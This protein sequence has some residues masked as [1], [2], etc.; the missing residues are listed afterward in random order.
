MTSSLV[1]ISDQVRSDTNLA[2]IVFAANLHVAIASFF[3]QSFSILLSKRVTSLV[4][5]Y[6]N[7]ECFQDFAFNPIVLV[8][9]MLFP[10]S[11]PVY[12]SSPVD[13]SMAVALCIFLFHVMMFYFTVL[14]YILFPDST[15][16]TEDSIEPSLQM[17]SF[18]VDLGH[19]NVSFNLSSQAPVNF[20]LNTN[21]CAILSNPSQPGLPM[22]AN[23]NSS[24]FVFS[25]KLIYLLVA[26]SIT[27]FI[28]WF[29]MFHSYRST[30]MVLDGIYP[31]DI[32][33][34]M[35]LS[36]RLTSINGVDDVIIEV[37]ERETEFHLRWCG[38][39]SQKSR[40]RLFE[41]I[42]TELTDPE[43]PGDLI[44]PI[45]PNKDTQN[46]NALMNGVANPTSIANSAT[47]APES[48]E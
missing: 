31:L 36:S 26:Q 40:Q 3:L 17:F 33:E 45:L 11:D 5:F 13:R 14:I 43:N 15:T 24:S 4:K 25:S 27:V 29:C 32:D 12:K 42:N 47:T 35:I 41:A 28:Q 22:V 23:N 8:P 16:A 2:I 6:G 44:S 21:C 7:K 34:E 37:M 10:F 1:V 19:H 30:R 18:S 48:A 38:K 9:H 20:Y 46:S 39:L